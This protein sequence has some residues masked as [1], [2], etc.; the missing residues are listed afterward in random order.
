MKIL[1]LV[2]PTNFSLNFGDLGKA[3]DPP[4]GILYIASYAKKYG[5]EGLKFFFCDGILEGFENTLKFVRRTKA[6]IIGISSVTPNIE[7][8]YRLINL[9]RKEFPETKLILGGPHTTAFPEEALERSELDVAVIGEGERTFTELVEYYLSDKTSSETLSGIDGICFRKDDKI[10]KTNPRK[11]IKD[12]DTIPFPA[13]KLIPAEKYQGYPLFKATPSTVIISSRGCPYNCTFCSNNVWK[14]SKPVYRVRSPKNIVDE[15]E[16]LVQKGYKEFFDLS[17]EFN[18]NLDMAKE[19]LREIVRRGLPIYYK[20]QLRAKPIDE[21][22][23]QL[24]KNAGVWYVHLGIES[25]NPE[26]LKGIRKM[27]TLEDVE[28]CCRL[29]KKYDIKIWG[30]FMYFNIWER[31]GKIFIEDYEKSLNTFNYAKKLY[32]LKL[33][34]YFGGSITTPMP[35]SELWDIAMRHH[36]IK[37]ECLG[38]WDMWFYKRDLRL[39]SRFPGIPDSAI[40]K[41][42]QKTFRYTAISLFIGGVLKFKNL[43]FNI[44]RSLYFL[45]RQILLATHRYSK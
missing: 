13:R 14:S 20:C 26:T 44:L 11:F 35:G 30:L 18:T 29:L 23:V 36:L 27:V 6:D 40:F 43:R 16:M 15:I 37:E 45:K 19:I 21:E 34:D 25:G 10:I 9:I 5:P 42:H 8:A 2:A 22:L 24:M 38:K 39:I 3:T 12:L 41:L 31:K 17:D 7:G 32:R 33:I 4:L 1:L 28:K